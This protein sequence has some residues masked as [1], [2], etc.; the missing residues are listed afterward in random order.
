M[1][2]YIYIYG[3]IYIYI[4]YYPANIGDFEHCFRIGSCLNLNRPG[5][6][7]S[8]SSVRWLLHQSLQHQGVG[9]IVKGMA[10]SSKIWP[11]IGCY[12]C[13]YTYGISMLMFMLMFMVYQ[14]ILMVDVYG[15]IYVDVHWCMSNWWILMYI[16][17]ICI[18]K[19]CKFNW[20]WMVHERTVG[21]QVPESVMS[22]EQIRMQ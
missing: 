9:G 19:S 20:A 11:V 22:T 3:Y 15:C 13:M 6:S 17:H 10:G 14:C 8:D 2:I 4:S 5:T 18:R 21:V 12:W 7:E 1:Y 16:W